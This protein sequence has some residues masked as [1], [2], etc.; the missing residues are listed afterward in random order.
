MTICQI[1]VNPYA[2]FSRIYNSKIQKKL[3]L[4]L[5]SFKYTWF[6]SSLESAYTKIVESTK[7]QKNFLKEAI[8]LIKHCFFY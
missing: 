7:K 4:N 2:L 5:V 1:F 3:K 6:D 8:H